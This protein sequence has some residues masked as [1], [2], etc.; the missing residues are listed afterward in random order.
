[1]VLKKQGKNSMQTEELIGPGGFHRNPQA[2]GVIHY[3]DDLFL[4]DYSFPVK[5]FT[6]KLFPISFLEWF[7]L[8]G[9]KI[10]CVLQ[11]KP[12]IK[13][14]AWCLESILSCLYLLNIKTL[15]KNHL[16]T[17]TNAQN[18][19]RQNLPIKTA[20]AWRISPLKY[21]TNF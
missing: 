21:A 17:Q 8:G 15:K 20:L 18:N 9:V 12:Q 19:K 11:I 5:N 16:E 14:G 2:Y 6:T 10:I 1:M 4:Y 3:L 13:F 7:T